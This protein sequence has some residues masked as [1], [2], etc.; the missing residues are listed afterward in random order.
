MSNILS[1]L[2]LVDQVILN[3][4]SNQILILFLLIRTRKIGKNKLS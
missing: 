4:S 3:I 2:I 1:K